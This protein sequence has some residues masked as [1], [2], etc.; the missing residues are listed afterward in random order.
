MC[1][2]STTHLF[3]FNPNETHFKVLYCIYNPQKCTFVA[4]L[5]GLCKREKREGRRP[6]PPV[7]QCVAT[8]VFT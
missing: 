5:N 2:D 8:S 7:H 1:H 4:L 6:S 3:L